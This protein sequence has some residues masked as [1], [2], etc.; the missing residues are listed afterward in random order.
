MR[1]LTDSERKTMEQAW[2]VH[3]EDDPEMA[4]FIPFEAGF[5]VALDYQQA[6]ID[7]LKLQIKARDILLTKIGID[8]ARIKVD[9]NG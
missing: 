1:E 3:L 5:V 9:D 4:S 2:K 7:R 6:E 8:P